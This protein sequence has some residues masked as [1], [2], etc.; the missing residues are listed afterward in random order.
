MEVFEAVQKRRSV[1]QYSSTPVPE[2]TLGRVLEAGRLA[3]S[4]KN[5]QPWHFVVVRDQEKRERL[6]KGKYAKFLKGVPVVIVGC[7]NREESPDWYAVDTAIAMHQMLLTATG[8]GLGTCWVGS[9]DQ[10]DVRDALGVPE[11]FKIVAM[12][13]LGYPK[14]DG[15]SGTRRPRK[16]LEE[17]ASEEQFGTPW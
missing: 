10:E 3:P 5:V 6:S 2:R 15:F 14:E 12:L 9:F 11:K 4:A 1:R 16:E 8:E 17:V 7:G 13:A